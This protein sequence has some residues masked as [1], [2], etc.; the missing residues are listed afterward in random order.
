[1]KYRKKPVEVDAFIFGYGDF[2]QWFWDAIR[3]GVVT[4]F[5]A[6]A[7]FIYA[8]I[9]TLEGVMHAMNGEYIIRGVRGEIYPCKPDIFLET[10]EKVGE[11]D[12]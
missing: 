4:V 11:E 1:M 7:P 6:D 12:G 8:D 3:D 2:P 9:K 5:D 10:Y